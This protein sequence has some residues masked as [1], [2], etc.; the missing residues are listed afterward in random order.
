MILIKKHRVA[1]AAALLLLLVVP[2]VAYSQNS[3]L[4]GS[5]AAAGSEMKPEQE[6]AP[7]ATEEDE[8]APLAHRILLAGEFCEALPPNVRA[9]SFCPVRGASAA[10]CTN[11]EER[12][13]R[14]LLGMGKRGETIAEARDQVLEILQSRNACAAWYQEADPDPASTF[15]SLE[16][17]VDEKG[18]QHAYSMKD[19]QGERFLKQPYV[20]SAFENAGRN[21]VIQ[22][23]AR[24]AFFNRTSE[25]F[26]QDAGGG[27]L[28]R[29]GWHVL[30]VAS[31]SGNTTAAQITTMLHELGHI[32]GRIP[33]DND[34]WDRLS[35]RNTAEVL[36]FCR[37][38]IDAVAR[39][40]HR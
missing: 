4:G 11:E 38:E 10:A 7:C 36:R 6:S 37:P 26:E 18:P 3:R 19:G 34:S 16:F 28:L 40:G 25:V 33:P 15:R 39:K 27:P 9:N 8:I 22:F 20:A 31:Y 29:R 32:V 1:A 24:G 23:N 21:A 5:L 30:S 12:V 2:G 13:Q 35:A 17:F 14:Q